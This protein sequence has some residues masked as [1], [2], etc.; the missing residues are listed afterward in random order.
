MTGLAARPP[1]EFEVVGVAAGIG[2]VS[3]ALALVGPYLAALT[4]ALAALALAGWLAARSRTPGV[5]LVDR[6]GALALVILGAAAVIYVAPP[7]G[8][9]SVRA[10]LL[11]LAL[12]PLWWTAPR[13]GP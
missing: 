13:K 12:V 4:G 3:G 10:L 7:V 6:G 11:G 5:A 1:L 8:L 9:A 2:V